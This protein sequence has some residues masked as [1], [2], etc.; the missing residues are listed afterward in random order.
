MSISE[1]LFFIG[2]IIIQLLPINIPIISVST[3]IVVRLLFIFLFPIVYVAAKKNKKIKILERIKTRKIIIIYGGLFFIF[4]SLSIVNA[5]DMYGFFNRYKDVVFFYILPFIILLFLT[6]KGILNKIITLLLL[7]FLVNFLFQFIIFFLPNIFLE[8]AHNI[9]GKNAFNS[10]AFDIQ[11]GRI[12]YESYDETLVPIFIYMLLKTNNIIFIFY[13]LLTVIFSFISGYRIRL[14]TLVFSIIISMVLAFEYKKGV[15]FLSLF[16]IL[17][18]VIFATPN[19]KLNTINRVLFPIQEDYLSIDNRIKKWN[20]SLSL[21]LSNMWTGVGLGN[22]Y[23]N[24]PNKEKVSN[25]ISKVVTNS[26]S[27]TKQDPHNIFFL[28]FAESGLLAL[29][30]Y[31]L[32]ILYF[33]KKDFT[34]FVNRSIK[35]LDLTM[36]FIISFWSLFLI[37]QVT[38]TSTIKYYLYFWLYRLII[39]K[40]EDRRISES[41]KL[42]QT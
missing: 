37:S 33:I 42:I 39:E 21:G 22:F 34:Y 25:S 6:N 7:G 23:L 3:H 18:T 19:L 24:L 28:I 16:I 15:T 38:P 31:L 11:R 14:L 41:N 40:G 13:I 27:I 35:P 10:V 30:S 5:I 20:D 9:I 4:Q 26:L 12:N 36:F 1:Y 29:V 32:M 17:V 8:Y 2:I